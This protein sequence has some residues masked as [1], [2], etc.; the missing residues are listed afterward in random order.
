ML[1]DISLKTKMATVVSLLFM[2]IFAAGA[3]LIVNVF[4]DHYK[5]TVADQQYELVA[6][7]ARDVDLQLRNAQGI[8][9]EVS[10]L[11]PVDNINDYS[12]MQRH[13][14]RVVAQ[15]FFI[16]SFFDDGIL[17]YSRTG[18][19]IA[20]VPYL[21]ER[22]GKDFSQ[23]E[24]IQYTIRTKVP[25]ISKPLRS[26]K[27]PFDPIVIFTAPVF[28]KNREMVAI[29]G[30][31]VSLTKE[32]TFGGI[33]GI[34]IGK[35]GH[36]YLYNSDR[37]IIIH[38]DPKMV[39]GNDVPRGVNRLFDR[40]IDEWFEGSGETTDQ[41]GL[42]VIGTFK[43][44]Q[45]TDWVLA[46]HY[47]I[48]DAYGPLYGTR[49]YIVGYT[50][51][52]IALCVLIILILMRKNLSPLSELAT[53][54]EEI[55]RAEEHLRPVNV[56][57]GGEIGALANSFNAMLGRLSDREESLKKTMEDLRDREA[58][59]SSILN[60]TVEGIVTINEQRL[61]ESFNPA[62]ENIFGY[63]AEE[64]I[65]QYINMLIPES[66]R[67]EHDRHIDT[68]L[69]GASSVVLNTARE[70]VG[71]RKNGS[72]FPI[73]LSISEA[74]LGHRRIFT[75]ILRDI[76]ERKK[77]DEELRKL[78]NAVEHSSAVIII[79]N[80]QGNIEYV[81]PK[82]TEV[83]GYE[84]GEVFDKTPRVLKSGETPPDVYEELWG[85]INSGKEWQGIFHNKKK[86][87]EFYWAAASISPLKDPKGKITHFV[88]IQEDITAIKLFE[89]E[90]KKAK[91]AAE[92]ANQAKSDF[93]ASMSHEIRTP[94][95]AI[96]GMSELLIDTPLSEEQK[97]YVETSKKAGENLLDIINDIL[98]LSK[99]E[100]GFLELESTGFSLQELLDAACDIMAVRAGARGVDLK[101]HIFPDVP[102]DLVGDPGRLRQVLLNLIGNAVKFTEKGAITVEVKKVDGTDA[103]TF[104][105]FSVNDTGIG[106]PDDK[107]AE[108]F[109]KFIQA[110]S[111]TTRKYGG[112]G[113]GL[114][115]SK[116]LVELMGGK[117][118]VTS[119]L[120]AGS[121]FYFTASFPLREEKGQEGATARKARTA[122]Q[123]IAAPEEMEP[124]RILL[125]DDSEDNRLLIRALLKKTPFS[126]DIAE[127]G[128]IAVERFKSGSYDIVLMDIQMPVMDG[129][130]ATRE[131][132]HWEELNNLD[133]VPILALTAYALDEE[134]QKSYDAGCN[135]HLT[136]P[137]K[138]ADL[139]NSIA[140][141]TGKPGDN[142]T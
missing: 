67:N 116:R 103:A 74:D 36:L 20:A 137:I 90:L 133:P 63:R 117:I 111:S 107:I 31:A 122:A 138:K 26:L 128:S 25:Y 34:K 139:L 23:R 126:I 131:I 40:A 50:A 86:N 72:T 60:T 95:N 12:S 78:Y 6:K 132:R 135:G 27:P 39:L 127:D 125:V 30:G 77:A 51:L 1:H 69:R 48:R 52:G 87:G 46:A 24:Y 89:L 45:N 100:A 68:Y 56:D 113:L 75:G 104:L 118:G 16:K 29:L 121:R 83:T 54:A 55:G 98:D 130:A 42:P 44:F 96:I 18:Q 22:Y 136:K 64:V 81:N 66:Y 9:V 70:V 134:I 57:A 4:E 114:A 35:S 129:Y 92:A 110:D 37:T 84:R 79:T 13:L 102:V 105:E 59:I 8:L 94:M 58:R 112:T 38:P 119:T 88:G 17:L 33:A 5:K 3:F 120:G 115:I 49:W 80:T 43:H 82:F 10:K 71:R 123:T 99:I 76:T 93:L 65:G 140:T 11:I 142:H 15:R 2:V 91:E 7:I 47:P 61:I 62:A 53:Q 109:E 85:T 141:Y 32:S 97:K 124:L 101:C 28:D 14:E 19:V 108:I 106:I 73:E 21:P 41:Q